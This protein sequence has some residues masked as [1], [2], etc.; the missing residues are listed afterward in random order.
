MVSSGEKTTLAAEI[1]YIEH[2]Q[3]NVRA[4]D[5]QRRNICFSLDAHSAGKHAKEE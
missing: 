3:I 2:L 5:L 1:F 4:L